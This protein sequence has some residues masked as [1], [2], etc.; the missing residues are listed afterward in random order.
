MSGSKP[1]MFLVQLVRRCDIDP[2]DVRVC[3]EC[4][5]RGVRDTTERPET[6][7]L[8]TNELI[9]TDATTAQ[10]NFDTNHPLYRQI[11]TLAD[12]R[13]ATPALYAGS[14]VGRAFADKP[15]L[16]AVSRIDPQ[17]GQEVVLAFNTSNQPITQRVAVEPR[18][19][20]FKPLAGQCALAADA[21]GSLTITLP[22][23]GYAVC[24]AQETNA[25]SK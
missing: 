6:V 24:A 2:F 5:C 10:S 21:P 1:H 13:K 8:G 20:T 25:S 4:V 16:F 17:T 9:G 18:S 15:G 19:L 22:A 11:A 14:T 7:T 23:F 3:A 12:V